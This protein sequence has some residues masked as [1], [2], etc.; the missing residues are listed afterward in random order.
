[1]LTAEDK[2]PFIEKMNVKH[3]GKLLKSKNSL[4]AALEEKHKPYRI[5]GFMTNRVVDGNKK[6]Y[7]HAW[8]IISLES[9]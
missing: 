5:E 8:R 4:N 3:N 1:M 7:L 6:K 2:K 9:G